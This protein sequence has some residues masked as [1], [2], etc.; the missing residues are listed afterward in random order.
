MLKRLNQFGRRVIRKFDIG[1]A[2]VERSVI[3]LC[4]LVGCLILFANVV[5]RYVFLMPISWAEEV[6]LYLCVW[7]VFVGGSVAVRERGH[8]AIDLLPQ[9]LSTQWRVL[10]ARFVAVVM[11]LLLVVFFWFSLLHVFRVWS[12]G[13]LTPITQVPMWL[14]YL[15][16]PVGSLLMAIRTAQTFLTTFRVQEV[17]LENDLRDMKD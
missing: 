17:A 4:L 12:S 6:A 7:L 14:A 11:F 3:T 5:F 2:I 9:I 8:I 1:L 13:Q 15:A 16:M 10:L